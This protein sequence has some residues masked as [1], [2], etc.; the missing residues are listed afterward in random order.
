M[1]CV[2]ENGKN[3]DSSCDGGGETAADCNQVVTFTHMIFVVYT[4]LEIVP[5][6]GP[7]STILL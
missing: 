3:K 4:W 5:N 6:I 7:A 1:S 2:F